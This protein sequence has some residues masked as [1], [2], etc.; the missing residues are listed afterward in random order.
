ME[1]D[2]VNE[3]DLDRIVRLLDGASLIVHGFDGIVQRWTAGCEYLYGWTRDE[4]IGKV[5]H[6]LLATEFPQELEEIRL[7]VRTRGFW[8]GEVSHLRKDGVRITVA[9][10]WTLLQL[11]APQALIVQTNNDVSGMRRVQEE[12]GEREAHLKSILATVPDAMV[13]IDERGMVTSF[14]AA[15]ERLFSYRADEVVGRNVRML[16]PSPEREA[17]DSYI[18]NYLRTGQRR[19]IGHGRVV[20]GLK[21]DGSTFPMELSVGEATANRTRTFTGFIRD[22]T[23]RHRI[24]AELRQSQKMEAIGQLTGGLAHDFNNLLAAIGG[25]LEMLETRLSDTSQLTLLREAQSAADDGAK[26]TT[27]LLAFGRRQALAPQTIDVG[28]LLAEFSELLQRT[29]GDSVELRTILPGRRTC[30]LVD[31]AQLQSALLNLSINARDAMPDGGRLTIEIS[32]VEIDSDYSQMYPLVQP[33]KYVLISV[34]DNGIGM[35]P[36]VRD[37]AFEPFFTT[38]APGAG[39]GLGLS[40][41]YGFAKQSAGH[42]QLYSEVGQGTTVRLF[43]PRAAE[44]DRSVP[45]DRVDISVSPSGRETILVVEDDAR[46]RRVT[47][48]RLT[49]LG[50][51][52]IEATNGHEAWAELERQDGIRLLFTDVAMPGGMNGDE[53]ASRVRES[54]PDMKILLTSGYSEPHAASREIAAGAGWL[55]KPYTSHELA[56]RLRSLLDG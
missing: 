12:L 8:T 55:K 48:A 25:N 1:E 50:Y 56:V 15:A 20:V 31:K 32:A 2:R 5:V 16:M 29:L 35:S 47:V 14:S 34:T 33:N 49:A 54:R 39:T 43:L 7:E 53:L 37:H 38:K 13:V 4:A 30:A 42:L 9:C 18:S 19:I 11:N 45:T 10:R 22:L 28:A 26:L 44:S 52:V 46:V 27:Q 40:M 36:D 17:H 51:D 6:D 41:V 21:K 23:S 24:E 3:G